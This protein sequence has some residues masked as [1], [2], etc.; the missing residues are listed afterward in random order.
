MRKILLSDV[1]EQELLYQ[2]YTGLHER[3]M[4]TK[5]IYV[6]HY[7]PKL[8]IWSEERSDNSLLAHNAQK[9]PES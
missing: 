6:D 2:R 5:I 8:R 3:S 9:L 1:L 4:L 7:G